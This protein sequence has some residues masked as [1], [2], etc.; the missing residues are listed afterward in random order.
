MI[1]YGQAKYE[2]GRLSWNSADIEHYREKR[3][4]VI[5]VYSDVNYISSA[6]IREKMSL[7]RHMI[8]EI[9]D[10]LPSKIREKKNIRPTRESVRNIHFPH[11]IED[12]EQAKKELGYSEL[13]RFQYHGIEKKYKNIQAS[14][15]NAI[16]TPIDTELMKSLI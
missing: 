14:T 11:S 5:P 2:Y 12:F 1:L 16:P 6:W 3:R 7:L 4:E 8:D 15:G 13:F 9:P 10:I